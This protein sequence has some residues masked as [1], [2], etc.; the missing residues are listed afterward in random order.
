MLVLYCLKATA[1]RLK[2]ATAGA[3]IAFR[4]HR[5]KPVADGAPAEAGGRAEP[6]ICR[7]LH[8]GARPRPRLPEPSTPSSLALGDDGRS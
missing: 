6:V 4:D 3:I 1:S 8:G 5:L 2:P 7:R